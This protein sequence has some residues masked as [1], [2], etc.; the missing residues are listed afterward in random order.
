MECKRYSK[1]HRGIDDM[2]LQLDLY[3]QDYFSEFGKSEGRTVVFGAVAF[4][5]KI[6]AWRF[7]CETPTS[8]ISIPLMDGKTGIA[9]LQSYRDPYIP[10]EANQIREFLKLVITP[11]LNSTSQMA[12]PTGS[13]SS[14]TNTN[15]PHS[16][17]GL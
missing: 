9:D 7:T 5:T 16:T 11:E 2:E 12:Y 10:A 8:F 17:E 6:R 13:S 4:G 3:V 14:T 15:M 1:T